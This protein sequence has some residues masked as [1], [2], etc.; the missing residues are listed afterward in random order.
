M[1]SD[2]IPIRIGG[3][4]FAITVQQVDFPG[5]RA[6]DELRLMGWRGYIRMLIVP[7][8]SSKIWHVGTTMSRSV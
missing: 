3:I 7:I 8:L 4:E 2:R 6:C 1:V 5:R